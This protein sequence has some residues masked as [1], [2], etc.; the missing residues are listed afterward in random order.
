MTLKDYT[1]RP[2]LVGA[3]EFLMEPGLTLSELKTL[4]KYLDAKIRVTQDGR[5]CYNC[6]L[7]L[8]TKGLDARH[9]LILKMRV[10]GDTLDTIGKE[11]GLSRDRVRQITMQAFRILKAAVSVGL[12]RKEQSDK[13]IRN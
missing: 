10:D 6:G 5:Y 1:G 12:P 3:Q 13:Q 2:E 8:S 9:V 11:L 4:R 7:H